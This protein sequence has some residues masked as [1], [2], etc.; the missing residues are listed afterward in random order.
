MYR[1]TNK[2][3]VFLF[4]PSKVVELNARNYVCES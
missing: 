3:L 2:V 1:P 4:D